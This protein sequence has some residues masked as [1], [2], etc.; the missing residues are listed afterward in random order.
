MRAFFSPL[1]LVALTVLATPARAQPQTPPAT[2]PSLSVASL[3]LPAADGPEWQQRREQ[4]VELLA[5]VQPDVL[6]I[7]AQLQEQGRSPAC[8]LARRLRYSCDFVTPD[9]PSQTHRHGSA[10][11]SRLTV[12][13]DGVTLLHPPGR[14]SAA[15]MMRVTVGEQPV[16]IYVVQLRPEQDNLTNRRHQSNDLR[17]WI[18]ATSSGL[19]S[20]VAGEF[21]AATGELVGSL[22]GFQPARRN[23]APRGT[24]SGP[25]GVA[26]RGHGLDVLYQVKQFGGLRQQRLELP[27]QGELP[28][29]RLGT[30]AVLELQPASL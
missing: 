24:P 3:E 25:A 1:L 2:L 5:T 28:A 29:L 13:E 20:V 26:E 9:R 16:N 10:M 12:S 4:I 21:S 23:P 7:H 22:P 8:W 30:L 11:L 19:P 6:A 17:T 18:E 27:A 14:Y 15:G